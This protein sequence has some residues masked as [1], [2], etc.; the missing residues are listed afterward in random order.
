MMAMM[1]QVPISKTLPHL[2]RHGALSVQISWESH[3]Q[4]A[5]PGPLPSPSS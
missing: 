5:R 2:A 3:F 1:L 4:M